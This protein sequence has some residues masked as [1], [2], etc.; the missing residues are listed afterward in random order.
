L[1]ILGGIVADCPFWTLCR[2]TAGG[3]ELRQVSALV[4]RVCEKRCYC[5]NRSGGE[6]PLPHFGLELKAEG[7]R[8]SPAQT[9]AIAAPAARIADVGVAHGLDAAL[10]WLTARGLLRGRVA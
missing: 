6:L 1:H 2:L 9:E 10:R 3:G 4:D 5:W 7:G 8:L